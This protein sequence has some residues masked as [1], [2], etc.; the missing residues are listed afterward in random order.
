MSIFVSP[1]AGEVPRSAHVKSL[2]ARAA[3]VGVTLFLATAFAA[4]PASASASANNN[5]LS[6]TASNM[7]GSALGCTCPGGT[8]L[9]FC[10]GGTP[11]CR[12]LSPGERG[13]RGE[14]T[15]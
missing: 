12:V 2:L 9:I 15:R 14:R 1:P 4:A 7:G 10:I 13:H 5:L 8:R 3:A 11:I 6:C